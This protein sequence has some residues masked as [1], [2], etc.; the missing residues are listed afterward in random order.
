MT[1]SNGSE[2]KV[3]EIQC[4]RGIHDEEMLDIHYFIKQL[5]GE[6]FIQCKSRVGRLYEK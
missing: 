4:V 2:N 5:L 3:I 1:N 6:D